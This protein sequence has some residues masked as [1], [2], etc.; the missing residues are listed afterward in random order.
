MGKLTEA[1]QQKAEREKPH[2]V[3][4]KEQLMQGDTKRLNCDVPIS[5]Y[6]KLQLKVI[7]EDTSITAVINQMVYDYVNASDD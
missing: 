1:M 6:K 3:D 5:V 4:V 7:R 2:L